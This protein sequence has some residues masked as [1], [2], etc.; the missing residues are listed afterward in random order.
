[1]R[2]VFVLLSL[3]GLM[4]IHTGVIAQDEED[5]CP[6]IVEEAI[7]TASALCG[8]IRRNEACYGNLDVTAVPQDD[9][10]ALQFDAPGDI[11]AVTDIASLEVASYD[12]SSFAWGLV[13]MRLQANLPDTLPGQNVNVVLFG[14]TTLDNLD[15][16]MQAFIFRSGIGQPACEVAPQ[17]L[18]IQTP[19]GV[20]EIEM[21]INAV[22]VSL[23]STVF[24]DTSDRD[25][26]RVTVLDGAATLTAEGETQTAG[27]G[28]QITVPLDAAGLADGPPSEPES[29]DADLAE[30]LL[31]YLR[32]VSAFVERDDD[33]TGVEILYA[34]GV[35]Q[36][37]LAGNLYWADTGI[38]L[39]SGQLVTVTADGIVCTYGLEDGG[40]TEGSDSGPGG[41]GYVCEDGSC[42]KS[43]APYGAL[44]A[45]I[46]DGTPFV[47]GDGGT[48]AVARG[49]P[50]YLTINDNDIYYEDN[51][52]VYR[53]TVTI[54]G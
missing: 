17:G 50:L 21:A 15:G 12:V 47:I 19:E 37:D 52:G 1:M 32:W 24:L 27:V 49:G 20:G 36:L 10:E 3:L 25:E 4:M 35:Y 5:E 34:D 26:M 39:E 51:T 28:G 54:A 46:G 31:F 45:R 48:F 14:E 18:L 22:T 2:R 42:A 23:G 7:V 13:F 33:E 8:E 43:G 41:Q 29:Y 53:V 16:S 44:L 30:L 38:M 40:C 9:V 11:A 6:V